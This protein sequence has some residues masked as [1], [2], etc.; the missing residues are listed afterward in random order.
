LPLRAKLRL[1]AEIFIT[2]VRMRWAMGRTELPQ[3]VERIRAAGVARGAAGDADPGSL[4]GAVM[5]MLAVLPTDSRCL[6]RSLV[7]LSLLA[8]RGVAA[9]LV[10]GVRSEPSFAAHAWVERDGEALLPSGDGE[11]RP[12]TVI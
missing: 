2:Y 11:F 10:I 1:G 8:R 12:L 3:L 9:T 4:A 5:G 6:V 7:Y